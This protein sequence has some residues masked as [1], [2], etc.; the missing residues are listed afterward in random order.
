MLADSSS[1][2]LY[3]GLG[4]FAYILSVIGLAGIF[5]KSGQPVWA[6]FIPIV[7]EYFLLKTVGRPGW[8]LLILLFVPCLNIIFGLIVLYDLSKSFGHGIGMFILLII[9]SLLT[10][11]YLGFSQDQYQGPAAARA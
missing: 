7:N 10:L 5:K 9:F 2:G 3:F 1:V 4:I 11:I 6:A 8:W